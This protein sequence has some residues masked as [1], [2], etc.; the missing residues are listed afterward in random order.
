MIKNTDSEI[1]FLDNEF[2]ECMMTKIPLIIKKQ[3]AAHDG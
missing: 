2:A 3:N 1:L